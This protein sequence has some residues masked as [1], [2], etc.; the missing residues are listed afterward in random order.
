MPSGVAIRTA[1]TVTNSV[2]HSIGGRLNSSLVGCQSGSVKNRFS[3]TLC[4]IGRVSQI[5][6]STINRTIAPETRA[7][8]RNIQTKITSLR[9]GD[10]ILLLNNVL[11]TLGAGKINKVLCQPRR[12]FIR[13]QV[14]GARN[15][16][17]TVAN[18]GDRSSYSFD[19]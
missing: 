15:R 1:P 13:N 19:W 3:P 7:I 11:H 5:R 12:R 4:R 16:K 17:S 6:N 10:K 18:V 8:P 2:P 14:E 9:D